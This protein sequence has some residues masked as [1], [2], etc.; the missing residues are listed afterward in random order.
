M[1]KIVIAVLVLVLGMAVEALAFDGHAFVFLKRDGAANLGHVGACF[2]LPD[3][4]YYCFA[5]ENPSGRANVPA[6]MKGFWLEK[7]A[8]DQNQVIALFR[9]KRYTD[10][11]RLDVENA[12]PEKAV[13]MMVKRSKEDYN[14]VSRNCE[15]DV[16]DVLHDDGG[17]G[18]TAD[19]SHLPWEP[20]PFYIGWVQNGLGPNDWFDKHINANDSGKM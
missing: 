8:N 2:Q 5:T 14:I 16:Y 4:T 1:N 11:K 19:A 17:Y 6:D 13:E 9:A 10:W 18:I 15:N 7:V 12:N 3:L 20:T